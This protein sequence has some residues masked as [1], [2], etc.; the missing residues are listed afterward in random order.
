MRANRNIP[1]VLLSLVIL[2]ASASAQPLLQ[3]PAAESA[4]LVDLAQRMVARGEISEARGIVDKL[5]ENDPDNPALQELT[6]QV[7]A[8]TKANQQPAASAASRSREIASDI[9][10]IQQ[11]IQRYERSNRDM[12][13]LVRQ[14][15]QENDMLAQTLARRN[16][17]L[18]ELMKKVYG[19]DA[20]LP[21]VNVDMERTRLIINGYQDQIVER[22]RQLLARNQEMS[23]IVGQINQLNESLKA[24]EVE[25][26]DEAAELTREQTPPAGDEAFAN[27]LKDKRG[28]LVDKSLVLIDKSHD[29]SLMKDELT[30]FAILLK[31]TDSK[32]AQ[33]IK[34]YDARIEKLKEDWAQD[35]SRQKEEVLK[36]R[37]EI[38]GKNKELALLQNKVTA[39][40]PLLSERK[41]GLA[42]KDQ[43]IAQVDAAIL[44]KDKEILK[45]KG[46]LTHQD[47][48]ISE[49]TDL[50]NFVD[51]KTKDLSKR[52]VVIRQSLSAGDQALEALRTRVM[53]IKNRAPAAVDNASLNAQIKDW[54][55]QLDGSL[56][57][58]KQQAATIEDLK[59]AMDKVQAASGQKDITLARQRSVIEDLEARLKGSRAN[60]ESLQNQLQEGQQKMELLTENMESFKANAAT[61]SEQ[62]VEL[63]QRVYDLEEKLAKGSSETANEM[64][65]LHDTLD[66]RDKEMVTLRKDILTKED[67]LK[68]FY[69]KMNDATKALNA[70]TLSKDLTPTPPSWPQGS[71]MVPGTDAPWDPKNNDTYALQQRLATS[72]KELQTVRQQLADKVKQL[73]E[74]QEQLAA[75]DEQL[76]AQRDDYNKILTAETA[77]DQARKGR[78]RDESMRVVQLEEKAERSQEQL[79]AV[80][81]DF[82]V[83]KKDAEQKLKELKDQE[84]ARP[85]L[86]AQIE[87]KNKELEQYQSEL[88]EKTEEAELQKKALDHESAK[89]ETLKKELNEAN[90]LISLGENKFGNRDLSIQD[91]KA[92]LNNAT[93]KERDYKA[94]I[95][96]IEGHLRESYKMVELGEERLRRLKE[97]L[98]IR[99]SRIG[100]LQKE[101]ERLRKLLRQREDPQGVIAVP[102]PEDR[103]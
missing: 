79:G 67:Q 88:K 80:Q 49:Q 64:K 14:L 36:L 20:V 70:N 59:A 31:D 75:K 90:R 24:E 23:D 3:R 21:E 99:E 46:L 73:T 52:V 42:Q 25:I 62:A 1:V 9:R 41:E 98:S 35:K 40:A 58:L 29:L 8:R 45:L 78:D 84:K 60:A 50:I 89:V 51:D 16:R 48:Q 2:S 82:E 57:T 101:V 100:S 54:K 65:F 97:Q 77:S 86:A 69:A 18:L 55:E 4:F 93:I 92:R 87:K 19:E 47:K 32:Y 6:E 39:Q 95:R 10:A 15:V 17:S 7:Q 28:H 68:F 56:Q 94:Q 53:Q 33:A 63:S 81:K 11:N 22:D 61:S 71:G 83:Y 44:D 85:D 12:E 37:E 26:V 5:R 103:K 102:Y 34:E 74:L 13:F 96:D 91:L 72:T 30:R 43:A 27:G 66:Q 38:S 76:R